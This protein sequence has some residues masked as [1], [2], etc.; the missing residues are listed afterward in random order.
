MLN[1]FIGPLLKNIEDSN[2][3]SLSGNFK[4]Q[5]FFQSLFPGLSIYLSLTGIIIIII[6]TIIIIMIIIIIIIIIY[7]PLRSGRIWH[8]VNF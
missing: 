3:Y 8:K 5:Y 2:Y 7:Q 1:R 6:I 4:G